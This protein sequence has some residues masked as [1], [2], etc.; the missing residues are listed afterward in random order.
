MSP[1]ITLMFCSLLCGS[2]IPHHAGLLCDSQRPP[3][4]SA[5]PAKGQEQPCGA[6]QPFQLTCPTS[7]PTAIW[8]SLSSRPPHITAASPHDHLTSGPPQPH[9]CLSWP[10]HLKQLHL[11]ATP[12]A[13][14]TPHTRTLSPSFPLEGA[15]KKAFTRE[16]SRFSLVLPLAPARCRENCR[17]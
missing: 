14:L 13:R 8:G 11:M 9:G 17:G 7:H 6:L 16:L 12:E 2:A 15:E 5:Q 10:L 3:D 1:H 4:M